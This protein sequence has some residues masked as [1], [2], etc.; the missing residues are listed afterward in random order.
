MSSPRFWEDT[1]KAQE[2][3]EELNRLKASLEQIKNIEDLLEDLELLCLLWEEEGDKDIWKEIQEKLNCSEKEMEK[4]SLY[5][6]LGEKYDGYNA[7]LSIHP[8]AGGTE[9]QDWA[10]MLFRMY[11]RWAENKGFQVEIIDLLT[12]D[13]A[14]IKS[15][16]FLVKGSNAYGYLKAEKG[17]HRLVRI[18]PFDTSGRRHTSFASVDV[19]PEVKD[20]PQ[21]QINTDDLKIDTFRAKGAG[22]QHV[23]KTDSAVRITHLPTGIVAQCQNERSQHSNRDRAMKILRGKLATLYQNEQE[24]KM[25]KLRGKQKEIA[26]GSQIRSY[27]FHPYSLVKDHRT[28]TEMGNVSGVMDGNIDIFI[29][30]FLRQRAEKGERTL[31]K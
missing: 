4:L 29:E 24:E 8:G 27:I 16:T 9:S 11:S 28:E 15:V 12:D 10:Q 1:G 3:I 22:G 23:N 7:I 2:I 13:E 25:A 5:F 14:G 21:L 6:L 20:S 18:S 31:H 30:N 17:V 26:W 19:I